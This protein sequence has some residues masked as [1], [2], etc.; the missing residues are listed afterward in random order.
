M[1]SSPLH[2]LYPIYSFIKK[3]VPC[4]VSPISWCIKHSISLLAQLCQVH[5][6]HQPNQPSIMTSKTAIRANNIKH[7]QLDIGSNFVNNI[8]VL[9][10]SRKVLLRA[11]I[12]ERSKILC[13]KSLGTHISKTNKMNREVSSYGYCMKNSVYSNFFIC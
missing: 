12:S 5:S 7:K 3:S 10:K 2:P 9:N 11:D 4:I 13:R 8:T 1:Y 6:T